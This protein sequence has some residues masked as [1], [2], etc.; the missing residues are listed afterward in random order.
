MNNTAEGRRRNHA[1]PGPQPL[2]A[3]LR[4]LHAADNR[5]HVQTGCHGELP[6]GLLGGGRPTPSSLQGAFSFLFLWKWVAFG[7]V[8]L[9]WL[10]NTILRLRLEL[11]AVVRYRPRLF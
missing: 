2:R 5:H 6:R 10:Y 11:K 1:R 8:G 9:G 7:L 3:H 4:G